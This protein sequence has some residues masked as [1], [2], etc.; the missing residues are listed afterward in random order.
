MPTPTF[1]FMG[2]SHLCVLL[3]TALLA[4]GM[5]A[6][7]RTGRGGALLII[8]RVLALVLLLEW[9]ANVLLS[10]YTEMDQ[11]GLILPGHLCDLASI[12]GGIALLTR[13][14]LLCELLYFWGLAG[15]MQGLLTPALQVDFPHVRFFM[16]FAVHVG[17]VV[18]ALYV[19]FGVRVIP[20]SGAVLRATGLLAVYGLV[21]GIANALL[22]TNY[23]FLCE[24]PFAGSM[25]DYLGPWPW[26]I[27]SMGLAALVFF[28][29]LD[30]PFWK[31]RHKALNA[32]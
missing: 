24:K 25:A 30:I 14:P 13:N 28:T 21:A 19:V 2:T 12:I 9:P 1:H 10:S 15:T 20:R 32:G 31:G 17:V 5:I 22:G 26:Y 11:T 27:G 18:A 6:L 29:L 4:A 16:F 8:E 7:A 3:L 23:G